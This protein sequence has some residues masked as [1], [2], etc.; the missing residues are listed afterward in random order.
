MRQS[1][2]TENFIK[3][4]ED[5]IATMKSWHTANAKQ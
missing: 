4:Q 3:A 1:D 5:G 2:L